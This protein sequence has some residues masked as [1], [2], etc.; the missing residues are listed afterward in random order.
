MTRTS[1]LLMFVCAFFTAC[2]V[3]S[4]AKMTPAQR[5][6]AADGAYR[7]LLELAVSYKE[8]C[9]ARPATQQALCRPAVEKMRAI[10]RQYDA[11]RNSLD[12]VSPTAVDAEQVEAFPLVLRAALAAAYT[13]MPGLVSSGEARQAVQP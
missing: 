12:T 1:G 10:D 5:L 13:A 6:Y 7:S 11:L 9:F 4:P 3:P 8:A 2:S